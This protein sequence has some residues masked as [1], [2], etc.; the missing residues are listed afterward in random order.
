MRILEEDNLLSDEEEQINRIGNVPLKW[1]DEF[2]HQGYTI[3][4]ERLCKIFGKSDSELQLLVNSTNPDA[5]RTIL[6][7][8]NQKTTKLTDE[9]LE[10]IQR[11]LSHQYVNPNFDPEGFIV[12]FD[13][14]EDKIFPVSN[15]P[16]TKRGFTPSK[17][18]TKKINHLAKLI[19]MGILKPNKYR[20]EEIFDLWGMEIITPEGNNLAT[21]KRPAH[22][23]APK[24]EPPSHK[25]SYNPPEEFL[26]TPEE[27]SNLQEMDDNEKNIIPQKYDCLRRVPGYSNLILERF[28]RCLDLYLCPRTI[29][30]RMNVDPKSILPPTIDTSC[31]KPYPTHVRAEYDI[32]SILK[33]NNIINSVKT[34]ILSSVSTDGQWI[35]IGCGTM[36]TIFEVIT[37][38]PIIS[39]NTYEWSSE[40]KTLNNNIHESEIDIS[41]V[42]DI[43]A[44]N[45]VTSLAFHPRLPILACG[46]EENLYILVLELPNVSYHIKQKKYDCNSTEYL[47]PAELLT[48]ASNLFNKVESKSMTLLSWYKCEPLLDI[49]MIKVMI[50][51]KHQAIIRQLNW[52]RKGIYLASVCPKS[53]S[54][55]HRIIIHSIDKCTSIK[56]Y[57]TKGFVRV[58]QFHTINPWLIIATQRS[59]R[60]IDLSNSKSSTKKLNNDN[61]AKQLVKKLVGIE[62]PTCLS[63]D[64]SGQYIFVGQSNGRVAWFDL[65][66]GNQPYKLLRYSETTIKQIQFHPNKSIMFSA[67]S[68]GDVNLFYCN[69]PK[70]IMSNPVLMPLKVLGGAHSNLRSAVWH[71][72]QPWIFCAGTLNSSKV[73]VLWG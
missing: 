67:N 2:D 47:T 73:V 7:I 63:L 8:K 66:L 26:M 51:V 21:S 49:P 64:Y 15:R 50:K 14:K 55:S 5:W 32:D 53:P 54:P 56:V 30:L 12:D 4:G 40:S 16:I 48:E 37:T 62:N 23:P 68:S 10:I 36:I 18:E 70:D 38:R 35:A 33:N 17:W 34:P 20:E 28:E 65:D 24:L 19:R 72:K 57:K 45:I 61:S 46:L 44:N 60:I 13:N 9:D 58:V 22:I 27:I 59:I 41:K 25:F 6:D 31:L 69:M 1:Y 52:H 29:K 39:W 3:D 42:N 11:V 43:E 71:P